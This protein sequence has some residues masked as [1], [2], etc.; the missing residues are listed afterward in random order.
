MTTQN[1]NLLILTQNLKV[2]ILLS[3]KEAKQS[4]YILQ[5]DGQ[6]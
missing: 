4:P 1:N 6:L 3:S 5:K 2:E